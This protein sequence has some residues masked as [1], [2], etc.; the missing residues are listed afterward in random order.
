MKAVF[1]VMAQA[2]RWA[3]QI[4]FPELGKLSP[5]Q[6]TQESDVNFRSIQGI[7]NHLLLADRAWLQRFTG[8]GEAPASVDAVPY[9]H[10]VDLSTVRQ[11]EDES[12]IAFAEA[13]AP[14][15]LHWTLRYASMSG[16]ACAEPY[17]VCLAHFYNHQT[18]H[19]GQLHALLGAQGIKA[20]NLD[21]IYFQ[22]AQRSVSA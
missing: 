18:F 10:C 9:P 5:A 2:N 1:T 15:L 13:L 6:W 11:A 8:Q 22:A 3:N 16:A 19:R 4:L 12:I 14:E 20:P 21:L 17:A 7:A